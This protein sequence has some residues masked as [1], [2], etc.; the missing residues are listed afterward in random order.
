MDRDSF[1]FTYTST[2]SFTHWPLHLLEKE[3]L[4]PIEQEVRQ[5]PEPVQMLLMGYRTYLKVS[6]RKVWQ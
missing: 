2:V 1:T 3:L 6:Y 4:I 5:A